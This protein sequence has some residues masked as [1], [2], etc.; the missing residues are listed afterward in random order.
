MPRDRSGREPPGRLR[1]LSRQLRE[2][3]RLPWSALS[4]AGRLSVAGVAAS[5]V[6]ALALGVL[7][8]RIV[9]HHSLG[10]RLDATASLVRVLGRSGLVP[11]LDEHLSGAAY[12]RF[13]EV[14]RG[15]LL[16]GENVRVKLWSRT[17]EIVYSDLRAQVGRRYAVGPE[18]AAAF[19][20]TASAELSALEDAENELDRDIG[21]RALEFYIPLQD[22]RGRVAGVFEIYQD[23]DPLLSH[24][25]AVR[26]AV[27]IAV[28][29]G[30]SV[31]LVFLFLLSVATA[32]VMER[33]RRAA[34]ERAEDLA[35]LVRISRILAS[36]PRLDRT[37]PAVLAALSARL[38]LRCAGVVLDGPG[39]AAARSGALR[40]CQAALALGRRA[41]EAG[42]ELAGT[43]H[44]GSELGHG[45]GGA[46]ERCRVLA[47][48]FRAGPEAAGALVVCRAD[49]GGLEQRERA[50]VAAVASHVGVAGE[51]ARLFT[52][53]E[54]MTAARGRLLRR[55]VGAQEE[56]RRRLVGDLHDGLG[57]ALTRVL[58]GLRG[59]RAR[60]GEA[61]EEVADELARLEGLVDE[62]SRGL[63]RF[64]A[65]VRPAILDDFGL[66]PAL[67]AFAA[68]QE[69]E[70]GLRIEA[71]VQPLPDLDPAVAVTL[72]RAAQ[73]AV[74]N[75]R[76][77]AR[78]RTVRIQVRRHDRA[79][80]LR[81]QDDGRG[82][83]RIREGIGLSYLRDR[84]ASLGGRVEVESRPGSGTT[85]IVQ[86]PL[87]VEQEA[88]TGAEEV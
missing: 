56:E 48:P 15:G 30:L 31:L 88:R 12:D 41:A 18:L 8:P 44:G 40:L 10:A 29:T 78:A 46:L 5:A 59:A 82:S 72:F 77:H 80:V 79:V 22:P 73:E 43:L 21:P 34:E 86:V 75:A 17:G 7:I 1:E 28:G 50:L 36:E 87:D 33:E 57:Q 2:R 16:G 53:L 49:D 45:D 76:K 60:L 20:G 70:S 14:V 6:L 69:A 55:L 63:R 67:S 47:V 27:W 23:P 38:D 13:D 24:L 3:G 68:E 85:V 83:E 37:G 51:E 54:E 84:A 61:K 39:P 32:R 66:A 26:R 81:V 42:T 62:Q 52:D 65:A 74:M 64:M 71:R 11:P 19:A 4:R 58:Y 25:A 35:V 9:E